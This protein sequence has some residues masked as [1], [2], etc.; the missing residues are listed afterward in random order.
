MTDKEKEIMIRAMWHISHEA[1]IF[2]YI[3]ANKAIDY[4]KQ[5]IRGMEAEDEK[6]TDSQNAGHSC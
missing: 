3:K 4:I 5:A 2:G 1:N 6:H